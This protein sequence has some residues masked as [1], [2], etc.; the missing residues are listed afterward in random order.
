M[1]T[2]RFHSA[3]IEGIGF[4]GIMSVEGP[5]VATEPPGGGVALGRCTSICFLETPGFDSRNRQPH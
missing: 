1:A 2:R 3:A 4:Y 5:Y